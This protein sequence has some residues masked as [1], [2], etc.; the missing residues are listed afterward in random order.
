MKRIA[1]VLVAFL[2]GTGTSSATTFQFELWN[3]L[4]VDIANFTVRGG[5]IE[6]STRVPSGAKRQFKVT[7]PDGKCRAEIHMDI[8][9]D[10]YLDDDKNFDFCK[11]SGLTIG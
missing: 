5:Q 10:R 6:G 2:L 3:K 8:G 4:S 7:L 11:Y 9:S 1:F